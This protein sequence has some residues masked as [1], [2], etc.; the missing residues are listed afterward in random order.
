MMLVPF[1]ANYRLFRGVISARK[2]NKIVKIYIYNFLS[3]LRKIKYSK[4]KIPFLD[5]MKYI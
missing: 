4:I 2:K 3:F 5:N 1:E